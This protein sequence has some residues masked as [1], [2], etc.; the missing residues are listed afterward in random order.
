MKDLNTITSALAGI[1][2]Q[3]NAKGNIPAYNK[4]EAQGRSGLIDPSLNGQQT[5]LP[6]GSRRQEQIANFNGIANS[7][8]P[9]LMMKNVQILKAVNQ[10]PFGLQK[11]LK[12]Q[13]SIYQFGNKD[14]MVNRINIELMRKRQNSLYALV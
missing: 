9:E 8:A 6:T 12:Q 4:H 11:H 5:T 10:T 1:M 7:V 14:F 3:N 2:E 13:D